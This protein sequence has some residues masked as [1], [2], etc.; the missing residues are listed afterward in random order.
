MQISDRV[1]S[2]IR[3]RGMIAPYDR[4][5]AGVSGGADS[6]CLLFLLYELSGKFPFDLKVVHIEH[7]IRGDE[8]KSDAAFVSLLCRRLGVPCRIAHVSAPD[9]AKREHLTLEEAGR[10]L[11]YREFESEGADKIALAHHAGD[12]AETMLF[13]LFRGS[14]LLG[15]GSIKP[16]RDK[17]IRP[18]LMLTRSEIESYCRSM[19]IDYRMDSTNSDND[20]SRNLIRNEIIPLADRI[21]DRAVCHMASAASELREVYD[22]IEIQANDLYDRAVVSDGNTWAVN[23]DAALKES[24]LLMKYVFRRCI[25]ECAG[26]LK[27]IG[28]SHIDAIFSLT[29]C[30]SGRKVSLPYSLEA[31]RQ[32][33]SIII[34]KKH[35][36]GGKVLHLDV[37]EVPT[38]GEVELPSGD[39][40]VFSM[41]NEKKYRDIS[42]L[43][44][45]KWINYDRIKSGA[46]LRTRRSGDFITI[47]GG[48]KKI[49]DL[50]I[51]EKVPPSR[52][53]SIYM[54]ADGNSIIWVPPFRIGYDY[55]VDESAGEVWKVEL[56]RK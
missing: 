50:F 14:G 19:D 16:V 3:E 10:V 48:R 45:T 41:D 18:L 30:Q 53:D 28:H 6:I 21:N 35:R 54:L 40:F 20:I 4:I 49:K 5:V 25:G 13:N 55:R 33:E 27:D 37:F 17:I 22:F 24:R 36:Q 38:E 52:R 15:L 43:P 12:V 32:F 26:S 11:R 7:G 8:S 2:F 9:F 23:V 39:I 47:K 31:L 1:E 42:A 46:L 51:E 34:Q 29:G 56:R 44:Y